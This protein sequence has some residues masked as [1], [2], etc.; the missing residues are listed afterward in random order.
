[1]I[2]FLTMVTFF[3]YT[4][5]RGFYISKFSRWKSHSATQ[6]SY[7]VYLPLDIV[8]SSGKYESLKNTIQIYYYVF[9]VIFTCV[10]D[11]YVHVAERL[12]YSL[13]GHETRVRISLMVDL[14]GR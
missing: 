2:D 13:S 10:A 9:S 11:L 14:P 12:E 5:Q 4:K 3:F 6:F 7:S 1:M 8:I